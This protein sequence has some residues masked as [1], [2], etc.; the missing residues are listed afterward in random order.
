MH[1][2]HRACW[3]TP[4]EVLQPIGGADTGALAV[5]EATQAALADI[6]RIKSMLK[7]PVKAVIVTAVLPRRFEGLVPAQRDFL[8]ATH[9]KHLEFGDVDESQLVFDEEP[10]ADPRP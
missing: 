3:P 7:K 8:A 1:K 5:R 6:R 2:F 9:I 4:D 10:P